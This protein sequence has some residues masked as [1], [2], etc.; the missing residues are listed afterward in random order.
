MKY[1]KVR[2]RVRWVLIIGHGFVSAQALLD[3]LVCLP[4][5]K[6]CISS[7]GYRIAYL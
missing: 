6:P 4:L 2:V 1:L 7:S 5:M 3:E